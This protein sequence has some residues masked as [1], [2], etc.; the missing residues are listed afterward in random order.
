MKTP[1]TDAAIESDESVE[2][3][4]DVFIEA[5]IA[6]RLELDRAALMG[7]LEVSAEFID[8]SNP[9]VADGIREVIAAARSNFPTN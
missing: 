7:A 3:A 9:L 8:Q 2:C 6:R 4:G 1:I 5:G